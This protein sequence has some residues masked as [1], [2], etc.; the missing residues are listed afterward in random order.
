MEDLLAEEFEA[1]AAVAA[2]LDELEAVDVPFG[3]AV[4]VRVQ[5]RGVH[6]VAVAVEVV[7]EASQ[8]VAGSGSDDVA[9]GDPGR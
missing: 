8:G 7:N 6:G 2:A 9:T 1:G 5:E 4:A 3:G